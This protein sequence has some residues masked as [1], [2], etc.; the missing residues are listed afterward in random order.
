ME[1]KLDFSERHKALIAKDSKHVLGWRY[2]PPI[3]FA[4]G[5]GVYLTDVDGKEYIDLT[6]GMMCLILGHSHPEIIETIRTQ[7]STFVHQSSWY[8]NPWAIELAE[9]ISEILP[10]PFETTNYAVTGSEANEIAM[11]MAIGVTG[12]FDIASMIRGLHGGSLAAEAVTSVGGARKRGMGP[13][14]IPAKANC[15][16]PPFYYRAPNGMSQSEWDEVSLELT[17][18]LIE[19]SSSQSVAAIMIETM[20]VAGGMIIPSERWMRGI[21][22]LADR[23]GALLVLD[24]AQLAPGRTGKMWGF[25]HYDIQPDIIT[26]AKGMSAGFPVCGAITT[27]D[28]ADRARGHLGVPW[29]GTYPQDPL[30]CAVALKQLQIVLRDGL[31]ERSA[32]LGEKLHWRLQALRERYEC[33]GDVRGQGLYQVLDIVRD[34]QS[35][36]PAADTAE[37]IR[38][39][40]ASEGVILISVKNFIRVCPPLIITEAELEDALASIERAIQ[41][42]ESGIPKNLGSGAIRQSSSLAA[43]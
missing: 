1:S 39:N 7:A 27:S 36:T 42:A 15:I 43:D 35:K 20:A 23:W 24:E 10:E 13:L 18:E 9:L 34:R 8:T 22:D 32:H 29:S 21:R 6:S 4:G 12:H 28:I 14:M 31:V 16:F 30:P 33:V 41:L 17:E 40:A 19:Q 25:Q 5:Q 37:R 2:D 38:H 3:V 11:R 26:F